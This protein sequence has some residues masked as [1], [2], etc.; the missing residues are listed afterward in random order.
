MRTSWLA[1]H[2]DSLMAQKLASRAYQSANRVCVGQARRVRF[3]SKGRGQDQHLGPALSPASG[4]AWQAGVAQLERRADPGPDRLARRSGPSRTTAAH[5]V[6]APAAPA[7]LLC[8]GTRR[9]LP[10]LGLPCAAHSR[11]SSVAETQKQA[12]QGRGRTRPG[13]LHAG[14]RPRGRPGALAAAGRGTGTRCTHSPATAPPSG[15]R[16]SGQQPSTLRCTRPHQ[17][18]TQRPGTARVAGE[19]Q[20]SEDPPASGEDRAQAGGAPAQPAWSPGQPGHPDGAMICGS[21]KSATRAGSAALAEV[22]GCVPLG[23]L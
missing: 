15:A 21:R 5:Q 4:C 19:L 9:R 20:L 14:H 13:A 11:R 6:R 10:W 7:S 18:T 17:K 22:W 3:R 16:A 12:R 1:E 2:I 8:P 23:A